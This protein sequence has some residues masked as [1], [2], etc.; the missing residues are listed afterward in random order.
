M[1]HHDLNPY[2]LLFGAAFTVL[3]LAYI[4]GHW[5]WLDAS[6]QWMIATVLIAFGVAGIASAAIRG[7]R[8]SDGLPGEQA[9]S[10]D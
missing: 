6:G 2:P 7:R 5:T 9:R 3:G 1:H 4:V 8:R 10:D